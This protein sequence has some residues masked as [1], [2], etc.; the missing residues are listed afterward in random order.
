MGYEVL[1]DLTEHENV[2]NWVYQHHERWDGGGYPNRL[3]GEEVAL[4]GRILVLAEVYDALAEKRSYKDAW[5]IDKIVAFFRAQA[6]K[7]F[8]PDVAHMVAD[9]LE[10]KGSRFFAADDSML[11]PA[12]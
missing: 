11:F 6:G 9:G 1:E 5:P 3:A 10:T 7:H 8:D 12:F 2:R 4:P